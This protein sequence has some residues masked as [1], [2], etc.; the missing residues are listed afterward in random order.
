MGNSASSGGRG[1]QEETVDFGRLTP[2]G[3]YSGPRDWNHAIVTQL[4]CERKLA[5]FY[6][7]LEDYEDDWDD[8]Q[9]LAA[10]K[11]LPESE[12]GHS[13]S[14]STPRHDSSHSN[15]SKQ[16][17]G[18][19]LPVAKDGIRCPEAAIYRGAVECPICF[20]VRYCFVCIL[21]AAESAAGTVLPTQHQ[22]FKML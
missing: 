19:R 6:R 4:I 13:E 9:I 11:D 8:E 21:D 3:V 22:S 20:L 10:R 2:Q 16:S 7:P 14:S 1:H 5:P 15:G 17:H 12:N 18:K